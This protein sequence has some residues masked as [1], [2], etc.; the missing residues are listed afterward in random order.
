MQRWSRRRFLSACAGAYVSVRSGAGICQDARRTFMARHDI[1]LGVQLYTLGDEIARDLDGTLAA[2]AR[3][4]YRQV[5]MA[6]SLGRSAAELRRAFDRAGLTCPSGHVPVSGAPGEASLDNEDQ[7]LSDA[8]ALGW[9]YVIVPMLPFATGSAVTQDAWQAWAR[10]LNDKAARLARADLKL[11]Y[12]NHNLE[13]A[14]LQGT[15]GFE[16]LLEH[17]DPKLVTFEMDAGWVAAAGADPGALLRRYPGRFRLMHVKD[18]KSTTRANF[19]LHMDST[20]VGSGS[21]DWR[22][23]LPAAYAAGVREFFVEQE[24]PFSMARLDA[25]A[26]SYRYL[27]AI[28]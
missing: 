12:H 14:P 9:R 3:I 13:F 2:L 10:R 25:L 7:L 4:G 28:P 20:E 24:P 16:I 8:H 21:M 26:A 15:T 22:H 27:A 1:R 23:L 6:G 19:A 17:T 18:V 11:G 5:E